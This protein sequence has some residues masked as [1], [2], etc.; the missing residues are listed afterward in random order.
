MSQFST[1]TTINAPLAE[2]WRVL[3]D[4]GTIAKWNPGVITSHN[5]SESRAGLGA[6]RHCD[7]GGRNYLDEAVVHWE[8]QEA[9]TMRITGTN[10]PFAAA[11]IRF[12]LREEN[13][14]TA[15]TVSPIYKLKMGPLGALLDKVYVRNNYRQG[16]EA[17]LAGL[18]AYVEAEMEV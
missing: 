2:V 14:A 1:E 11:D 10:L 17:L 4:I 12:T 15:V 6:T 3:A 5:T 8:P 16:M 18:K 7:L 9:L 13:G